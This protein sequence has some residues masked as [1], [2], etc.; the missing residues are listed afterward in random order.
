MSRESVL[1]EV[2]RERDAAIAQLDVGADWPAP[3]SWLWWLGICRVAGW[4]ITGDR[5]LLER[6]RVGL[7]IAGIGV[8]LAERV[9]RELHGEPAAPVEAQPGSP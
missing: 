9:D 4:L 3:D 8:A 6:R 7:R 2:A 5:T 1:A